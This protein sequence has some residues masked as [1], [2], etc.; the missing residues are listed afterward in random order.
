MMKMIFTVLLSSALLA[1][2]DKDGGSKDI[3]GQELQLSETDKQQIKQTNTF[4]AKLFLE[5]TK[6]LKSSDNAFLSPFGVSTV[7]AMAYNGAGG[8]TKEAISKAFNFDQISDEHLN[9]YYQTLIKGLPL[10]EPQT[11]LSM[12]NAIWHNQDIPLKPDFLKVNEQFYNAKAGKLDFTDPKAKDVINDWVKDKTKNKIDKIIDA[13]KQEDLAYLL[14]AIY[15]KGMWEQKFDKTNTAK[16]DFH[17]ASGQ[18]VQ[19]DFMH[20][21]HTYGMLTMGTTGIQAVEIPYSNKKFSMLL[22]QPTDAASTDWSTMKLDEFMNALGSEQASFSPVKMDLYLP[23]FKFSYERKLNGDL[24]NL[25]M[26]IA[27][28]I[29]A[30]FSNL[31]DRPS[32]IS[33]VKHKAFVEVDEEGTEAAAVTSV[34]MVVTSL[35][36]IPKIRF[37]HPFIFV[38]KENKSNLI[39]FIGKINNPL[40][41]ETKG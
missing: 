31:S 18:T 11:E 27:F 21:Q 34:G 12:G 39:L 3:H 8:D 13:T 15:F 24:T 25:G 6:D 19:A 38:V 20:K 14:N 16:A 22:I 9:A 35:P 32:A 29:D 2:C 4:T 7:M 37:D 30:N 36:Q 23:K 41:S 26:G 33:E 10:V 28:Q 5:A 1:S 40:S 17:T